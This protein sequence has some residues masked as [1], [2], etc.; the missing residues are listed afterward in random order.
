MPTYKVDVTERRQQ[1]VISKRD[2]ELPYAT[3]KMR[4]LRFTCDDNLEYELYK[5][6]QFSLIE[7]GRLID[8]EVELRLY[9]KSGE[10]PHWW[11][12][13]IHSEE[14]PKPESEL[15]VERL[16]Q[17]PQLVRERSMCLSYAKDLAAAGKINVV[18][19]LDQAQWLYDWL[20]GNIEVK[21]NTRKAPKTEID[22]KIPAEEIKTPEAPIRPFISEKRVNL[23]KKIAEAKVSL[24][25]LPDYLNKTFNAPVGE[26]WEMVSKLDEKQL[27][28]FETALD[29][30]IKERE[31]KNS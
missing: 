2:P 24:N 25:S 27:N 9:G 26:L 7:V 23:E 21:D 1:T 14:A 10:F 15:S 11:V 29:R 4:V 8:F 20:I 28:K 30:K 6:A 18:N 5:E 12:T 3:A 13:N 31:A 22:I 17:P 16:G 19:I